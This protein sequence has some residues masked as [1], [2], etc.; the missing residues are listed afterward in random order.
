M[1][2]IT[3]CASHGLLL[4]VPEYRREIASLLDVLMLLCGSGSEWLT[5]AW[6]ASWGERGKSHQGYARSQQK[7]S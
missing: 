5:I 7:R 2:E 3:W 1:V 4:E 6:E